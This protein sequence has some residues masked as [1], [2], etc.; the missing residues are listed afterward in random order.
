MFGIPLR[1]TVKDKLRRSSV[2]LPR[3]P[4]RTR[5]GQPYGYGG[6]PAGL[7]F[8]LLF[9]GNVSRVQISCRAL[10]RR[11]VPRRELVKG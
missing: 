8:R 9:R 3:I 7:K 11:F 5:P 10:E 2:Y 6:Q 1:P 4:S